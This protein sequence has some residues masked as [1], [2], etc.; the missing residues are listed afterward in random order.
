MFA[1]VSKISVRRGKEELSLNQRSE[2]VIYG[3][4]E[5]ERLGETWVSPPLYALDRV[6]ERPLVSTTCRSSGAIS[7]SNLC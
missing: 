3:N 6:R 2:P 5:N 1:V 7:Q 4:I